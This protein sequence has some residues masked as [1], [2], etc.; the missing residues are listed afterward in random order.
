MNNWANNACSVEH[1]RF[2]RVKKR[3]G[4]RNT[5]NGEVW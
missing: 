5:G 4:V 2:G 3:D 1:F